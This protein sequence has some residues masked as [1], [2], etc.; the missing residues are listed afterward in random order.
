MIRIYIFIKNL[1]HTNHY[2]TQEIPDQSM[3]VM[4]ETK[5]KTKK[6]NA[7]KSKPPVVQNEADLKY[8]WM[9]V[10]RQQPS[11]VVQCQ[12]GRTNFS[13]KQ[14]TELEKEFNYHKYLTKQRRLEVA[15]ELELNEQQ[16]KLISFEKRTES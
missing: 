8:E 15:Q 5:K 10:K 2:Y 14:L 11:T 9:K 6:K 7:R 1:L 3:P 12:T 13:N 16:G 4:Q